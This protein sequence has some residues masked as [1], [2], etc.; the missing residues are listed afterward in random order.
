MRKNVE[1]WEDRLKSLFLDILSSDFA[2]DVPVR[3]YEF[4]NT[5]FISTFFQFLA[6]CGKYINTSIITYIH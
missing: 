4:C 3:E 6:H 2:L 1:F 5:L